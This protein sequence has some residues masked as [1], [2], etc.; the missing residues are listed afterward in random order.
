MSISRV[1]G[2]RSPDGEHAVNG[3]KDGG[4]EAQEGMFLLHRQLPCLYLQPSY[5]YCTFNASN[6]YHS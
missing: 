5:L 1:D 6:I 3:D 4:A 2:E